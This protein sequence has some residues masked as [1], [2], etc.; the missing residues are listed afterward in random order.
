MDAQEVVITVLDVQE[1]APLAVAIAALV[2]ADVMVALVDAVEDVPHRVKQLVR[3]HVMPH[4]KARHLVLLL[5]LNKLYL[6]KEKEIIIMKKE[7]TLELNEETC[8]YLQRLSYEVMTRKDVVTNMLQMAKDDVDASVLDS[9]P[10]KR[11]HKLLE[12]A[13]Y[14][15]DIAKMELENHVKPLVLEHEGK[16]VPFS[17][18]VRDFNEHLV[19]ITV[20][21]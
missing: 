3:R 4:V 8:N 9:I 16:D 18:Q 7:F 2:A 13:E 19:W 12:E 20:E 5:A 10:F 14:A 1:V 6:L 15:Y 21:G 11:Y 17:W